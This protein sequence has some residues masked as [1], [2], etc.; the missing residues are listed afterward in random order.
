MTTIEAI[1]KAKEET[2]PGLLV[3]QAADILTELCSRNTTKELKKGAEIFYRL[4]NSG[5]ENSSD[6]NQI[7][8]QIVKLMEMSAGLIYY[9]LIVKDLAGWKETLP[10]G[11]W[12]RVSQGIS[13]YPPGFGGEGT[14]APKSASPGGYPLALA[15]IRQRIADI[16]NGLSPPI[17]SS[18]YSLTRCLGL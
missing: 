2:V 12:S 15:D 4:L 6:P 17:S 1:A 11:H 9:R 5:C 14:S 10:A 7:S 8:I 3:Y 18:N 13:G 16:R